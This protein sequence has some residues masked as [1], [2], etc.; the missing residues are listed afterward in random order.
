MTSKKQAVIVVHGM[1]EQRPMGT[2]RT[3]VD[4]LWTTDASIELD[5][6]QNRDADGNKSWIV[7]DIKTGSHD[8]Q[9]ITTPAMRDGRRTDFFEFYY[10]DILDNAKLKNL[11]RW[12]MRVIKVKP[13]FVLERMVWPWTALCFLVVLILWVMLSVLFL[14]VATQFGIDFWSDPNDIGGCAHKLAAMAVAMAKLRADWISRLLFDFPD[15]RFDFTHP[16]GE[17]HHPFVYCH[18]FDLLAVPW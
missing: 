13:E 15:G 17:F 10:A 6:P 11:W 8:L 7:P 16:C 4:A 9:R 3:I 12:L 5:D 1:G 18:L 14:G 2:M